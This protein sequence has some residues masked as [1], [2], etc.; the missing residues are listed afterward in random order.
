MYYFI[1]DHL[2]TP[3]KLIDESGHIV[4]KAAYLPFGKAQIVTETVTNNFRFP[5]QYFDTE[6]GLHYNYHR[7]YDPKLGRYLRA[8]P[9]GLDGGINLYAY[10]QNDP[11]NYYDIEGLHKQDKWYGYNNKDFHRWFHRCWKDPDAP[12]A[13]KKEIEEA[14]A[15]WVRS[16]KP[17]GAKCGSGRPVAPELA[18]APEE[19]CDDNCKKTLFMTGVG[20]G[21]VV[22]GVCCALQPEVCLAIIIGGGFALN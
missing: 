4:W 22:V 9:M 19:G 1:N 6:T 16:G 11:V 15:E 3:R 2:D 20:A 5:G 10:V 12:N 13:D 17:K 21:A 18:P 14:Y 7:Y 8:D